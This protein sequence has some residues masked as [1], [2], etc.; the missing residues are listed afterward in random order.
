MTLFEYISVAFSVV[1]SLSAAQLLSNIRPL[2]DPT[3][4]DWIHGLWVVHLLVLHV[5]VWWSGWAFRDVSWNLGSFSLALSVPALLFV[6]AN[7]LVPSDRSGSLREH[8]LANRVQFFTARGVLVLS[9]Y[10]FSF[11]FL[12][13]PLLASV[14]LSGV[15]ILGICAVGIVST[16]RRVQLGIAIL[17][18]AYEILVIGYLRFDAGAWVGSQ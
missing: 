15:F 2:L 1:L 5:V 11:F 4:R 7:A 10:A 12:G 6:A 8:F 17:G 16:S 13:T 18:L 9:S 3:R 14:R